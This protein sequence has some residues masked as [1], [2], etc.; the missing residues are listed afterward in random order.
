[1]HRLIPLA[2]F[3]FIIGIAVAAA[4]GCDD[5]KGDA[6]TEDNRESAIKDRN[7]NFNRAQ[8]LY[9][10]PDQENFPLRKDLVEFTQ[11]QDLIN[12]PWYVYV[13]P[14]L[15]NAPIGYYVARSVPQNV[16]NFLSSTQDVDIDE[17]LVIQAPSLDGI[18]YGG[19]G[20]ANGC[21]A[22]FFF[23]YGSNA[24]IQIGKLGYFTADAPLNLSVPQLGP[25]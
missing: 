19:S 1:M 8:A 3:G 14:P 25:K 17:N 15:G 2:A 13:F 11:R 16:C 22:V 12:H 9:P 10:P 5:Y 24:L 20:A 7:D 21:D 4:V 23:D 18:F 6:T